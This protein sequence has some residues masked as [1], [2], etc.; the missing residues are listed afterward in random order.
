MASPWRCPLVLLASLGGEGCTYEELG[1]E[2]H[3]ASFEPRPCSGPGSLAK[4]DFKWSTDEKGR[5]RAEWCVNGC[6]GPGNGICEWGGQ[7]L[8]I[9]L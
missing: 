4:F 6:V 8:G 9:S 5:S 2:K 7:E 3:W 1:W